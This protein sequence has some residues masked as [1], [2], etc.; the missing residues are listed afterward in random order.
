LQV[1]ESLIFFALAGSSAA[2]LRHNSIEGQR[3][4]RMELTR[5]ARYAI[6]AVTYLAKQQGTEPVPSHVMAEARKIPERF[7]LKVLKPLVSA[8]ILTSLKGPN[9]GYRLARPS[10]QI[11][12][13]DIIETINGPI[14]GHPL[15]RNDGA[16]SKLEQAVDALCQE[17]AEQSRRTFERVLVKD[18]ARKA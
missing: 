8:G 13:L 10:G 14:G 6:A 1:I 15:R 3:K 2:L 7:L 16:T 11:S 18:L 5:A 4:R 17:S 12:L 9:G